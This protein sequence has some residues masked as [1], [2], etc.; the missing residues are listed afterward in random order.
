MSLLALANVETNYG[1]IAA[2]RGVSL[3]VRAGEIVA[4]L[5][6]NGAGKTTTLKTIMGLLDDQPEKGTITFDGERID[7]RDTEDI[8]RRGIALVPEGRQVF[9]D[10]S[11]H[12]NLTM[13]AYARSGRAEIARAMDR[14][15]T[16]FPRLAERRAQD[17]GTLS[18][19]EQQ[20]LAIGRGLMAAPRLLMLDEPSLGLAPILVA[21]I[22][23]VIAD[24][25]RQGLTI[26]LVEQNANMALALAGRAYV[27]E[28]GRVVLAGESAALRENADIK[29]FYL[30]KPHAVAPEDARR[31]KRKKRWQ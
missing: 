24:L 11:V 25:N 18:G 3:E 20:M 22:D 28:S 5:G 29:E 2:L 8:V 1:K 13:G 27:L 17:A 4:L 6:A 16:I 10:L 21:E 23:R 15:Y 30:G 26:L 9:P 14:V 19:G 12:E 31:Y 7:G